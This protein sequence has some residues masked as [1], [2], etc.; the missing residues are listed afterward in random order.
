MKKVSSLRPEPLPCYL[1]FQDPNAPKKPFSS[2]MIFS[3]DQRAVLKQEQP[4]LSQTDFAREVG[5][6]WRNLD[7][8]TRQVDV[9]RWQSCWATC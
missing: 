3:N 5:A 4:E 9:F 8:L 6:R 7:D 1:S 2:F